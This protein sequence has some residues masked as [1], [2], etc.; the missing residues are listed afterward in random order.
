MQNISTSPHLI[1]SYVFD[2]ESK[3]KAKLNDHNI[4]NNLLLATSS[5]IAYYGEKYKFI[6]YDIVLNINY[7]IDT[8][9]DFKILHTIRDV[10]NKNIYEYKT[11]NVMSIYT[12][13]K[14]RN[15]NIN[16]YKVEYTLYITNR[17][18]TEINLLEGLIRE[19][20][21][22]F[23]NKNKPFVYQNNKITLRNG[24][25]NTDITNNNNIEDKKTLNDII[26]ILQIED[27]LKTIKTLSYTEKNIE[28]KRLLNN[29]K[30]Y[31]MENIIL[32]CC[33]PIVNLFRPL[34]NLN[35][36]KNLINTNM[37]EGNITN[38]SNEFDSI[39]G[40]GSFDKMSKKLDKLY[41]DFY[42]GTLSGNAS[43][44]NISKEYVSI[45]DNFIKKYIKKKYA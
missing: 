20:N 40:T 14:E 30:K 16:D 5:M 42:T 10:L 38:I 11:N 39:L 22:I 26:C 41:L 32:D 34:F 36:V 43:E 17:K 45:R 15:N 27:I 3:L 9:N 37:Y 13:K 1:D 18:T 23:Q 33:L 4:V 19:I 25:S 24:I 6:I 12:I 2:I 31:D 8:N 35:Y 28:L 44:Y 29:I 7:I 21:K